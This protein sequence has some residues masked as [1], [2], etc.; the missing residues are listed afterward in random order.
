MI[1]DS[2]TLL[3]Q[4]GLADLLVNVSMLSMQDLLSNGRSLR[5]SYFA[6]PASH[7]DYSLYLPLSVDKLIKTLGLPTKPRPVCFQSSQIH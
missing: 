3:F 2:Q 6:L 1:V 7:S 4:G 5:I